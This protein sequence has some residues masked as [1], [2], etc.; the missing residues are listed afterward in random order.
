MIEKTERV[1][2][3]Y[4][5]YGTLLTEKLRTFVEWYYVDDWSLAEIAEQVGVTRQAVHDNVRRAIGQ[6]E[7]YEVELELVAK[8]A[9]RKRLCASLQSMLQ[10]LLLDV[11]T[12]DAVNDL[13]EKIAREG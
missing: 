7:H 1:N 11:A 8:Y 9:L 13:L 2:M 12:E 6:L 4:D 3:L 5:F 10:P